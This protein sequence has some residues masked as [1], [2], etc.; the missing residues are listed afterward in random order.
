M[1][2]ISLTSI[3]PR[4]DRL[5]PLLDALLAQ[6]PAPARVLLTLPRRYA[7]FPGPVVPPALPDAVEILWHD[8]D[9]GPATKA[10]PAARALAGR[11][12]RLIWCDDDW[13]A[14]PGW[15]RALIEAAGP[16]EAATGQGFS[17]ARLGRAGG[18]RVLGHVDIAQ[19][20]S[21]VLVRP[22]WLTGPEA[23][24]PQAAWAVDDIWLSGIL[25]RRGIGL[26]DVPAARRALRP[27]FDDGHALQDAM[28]GGRDRHEANVACLDALHARFGIWPERS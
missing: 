10:L 9:L 27:A 26:R 21:G 28:I 13:I 20:F 23:E 17:V 1:Y 7:R 3:P 19:G 6:R 12:D 18:T 11:V 15:A 8:T 25:A 14:G 2:A 4:L 5:G 22:E 16:D 24:P